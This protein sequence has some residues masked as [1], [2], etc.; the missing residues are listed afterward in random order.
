M[1]EQNT[2]QKIIYV[3][4]LTDPRY[5]DDVR[6]VGITDN[7]KRRLK[8]HIDDAKNGKKNHRTNWINS[9][10]RDGLKPVMTEIDET[11]SENWQACEMGWIAYHRDMGCNL[12]NSTDGGDGLLNPN[13]ATRN[14][15]SES[16]RGKIQSDETRKRQSIAQRG[17]IV[18]EVTC[19]RL[20][21]STRGKPK[22]EQHRRRMSETRP[23][24]RAIL[25]YDS[26]GHFIRQWDSARQAGRELGINQSHI[27][28]CCKRY[29]SYKTL[30]GCIWR[31]ADDPLLDEYPTQLTIDFE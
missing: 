15:M 1:I 14:K 9:L 2:P 29:K 26:F 6:Y 3:Y 5:P 4:V 21:E 16:R 23:N 7:S 12:V 28:K 27:G 11:N 30:G 13:E 22:S 17:K 10:L 8:A 31:Y 24:K 19:K 18:S 20:S 25:Q